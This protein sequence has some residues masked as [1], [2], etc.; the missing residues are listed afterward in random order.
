MDGRVVWSFTRSRGVR[1]GRT[2]GSNGK[3]DGGDKISA[4]ESRLERKKECMRGKEKGGMEFPCD[5]WRTMGKLSAEDG[6]D[7]EERAATDEDR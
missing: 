3:E 2:A 6:E 1:G 7:A 4:A 5:K